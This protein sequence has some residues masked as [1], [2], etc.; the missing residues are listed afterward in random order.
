M[1]I[2]WVFAD[3]RAPGQQLVTA[4]LNLTVF[5]N[6]GDDLNRGENTLARST[7]AQNRAS[8]SHTRSA[9]TRRQARLRISIN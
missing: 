5:L 9:S 7:G 6:A 3:L 2:A 4:K 8:F 1:C